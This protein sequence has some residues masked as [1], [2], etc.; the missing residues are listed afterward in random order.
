MEK[1]IIKYPTTPQMHHYTT[2]WNVYVQN[3]NDPKLSEANFHAGLCHLEQLLK[4]VQP[5]MLASFLF[6][7]EKIVQ[8][9]H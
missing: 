6:I 4:N 7:D 9:S 8:W 3:R 5:M 2:L 1:W